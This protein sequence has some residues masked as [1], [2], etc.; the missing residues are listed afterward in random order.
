MIIHEA[1]NFVVVFLTL[2]GSILEEAEPEFEAYGFEILDL[3][4]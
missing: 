2:N 3:L 1:N 4:S